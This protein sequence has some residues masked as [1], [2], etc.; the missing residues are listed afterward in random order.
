MVVRGGL[1]FWWFAW[2]PGLVG[3]VWVW[4]NIGF[5]D[6]GCLALFTFCIELAVVLGG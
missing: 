2:L 1:W 5:S 6:F 4:Y 3:F